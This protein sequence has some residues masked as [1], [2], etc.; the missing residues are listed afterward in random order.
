VP[1]LA[2][3]RRSA[4]P[5][6]GTTPLFAASA[7]A[8]VILIGGVALLVWQNA[9]AMR[10]QINDDFN[11]EQL[12]LARQAAS[13][14]ESTLTHVSSELNSLV[15]LAR[16][17]RLS[18]PQL[19][20]AMESA[21]AR[22]RDTGMVAIGALDGTE[23][24][25]LACGAPDALASLPA[26]P[27]LPESASIALLRR[28]AGGPDEALSTVRATYFAAA[29]PEQP[30]PTVLAACVDLPSLLGSV[31]KTVRS[32]KTGYAWIIDGN[33]VFLYHPDRR[34]IG[35]NAFTA[36][37]DRR[38]EIR[39]DRINRIMRDDMLRGHEGTGAYVSGWHG[40]L[41]GTIP[42]LIAFTPVKHPFVAEDGLWSIAVVAPQ[43]EVAQAVHRVFVRH[44]AAEA[45]LI[46]AL[47]VLG[48]LI[49][50][51]Q[52]RISH[53]LKREVERTQADLHE[54]ERISRRVV[55]QAS[56][57]IYI[58]DLE[59]RVILANRKTVELFVA[60]ARVPWVVDEEG[61]PPPETYIGKPLTTLLRPADADFVRRQIERVLEESRTISYEHTVHFDST[62]IRLDTKLMPIR[63][64]KRNVRYVLGIS[65]DITESRLLDQ[66]IYNAEKLA[67][68]GT[69][70]AGV[71]HEINNPLA[72]IL[73]FT[74]LLLERTDPSTPEHEDLQ[75]IE[76]QANLAK[77][78]V[79]D[80][81]GFARVT[82]GLE[83]TADIRRSLE[84]VLMIAK[85]TLMTRKIDVKM[86]VA[87]ELPRVIGDEREFQQVIF[88]L[89][90]NAVAAMA[91][92]GGTLTVG[93][94]A[95][96]GAVLISVA[97]TGVGIPERIRPHIFDPFFTTKKVNEGTGLGLSLC[98]GIVRKYG[99]QITCESVSRVDHPGAASGTTFTV[100]LPAADSVPELE[101]QDATEHPRRR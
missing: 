22:S 92:A 95:R 76:Y 81:L 49:T 13:Q 74:D 50:T 46:A 33:G 63:D 51:Y 90:N 36:R 38:P 48:A 15:T 77:K 8:L 80:L 26:V 86:E 70:A 4:L 47:V 58:L 43:S 5:R 91:A 52:R 12:V 71:A 9:R 27:A 59:T 25:T 62:K 53:S 67:S 31:L 73:G 1:L 101:V 72:V 6:T 88:N 24:V 11:Q 28:A 87:D 14:I 23:H 97:D 98:Y 57:L 40:S 39:F 44:V 54:M 93:A 89:I 29:G 69:L 20:S 83:D 32:G 94:R 41:R 2:R 68:I 84:K 61:L 66:R 30:G 78:V 100:T 75:A 42:K 64:D 45:V 19:Q 10:Q 96:D 16:S 79:E 60:L 7:V 34:F 82:E 18:R 56:D 35:R 65:R 85:N 37:H 99:G 17:A 55:E 3:L 21:L